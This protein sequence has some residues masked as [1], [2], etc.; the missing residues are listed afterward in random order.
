[1]SERAESPARH[2][3]RLT[4]SND[5]RRSATAMALAPSNPRKPLSANASHRRNGRPR[6]RCDAGPDSRA[7]DHGSPIERAMRRF[8]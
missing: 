8:R 1:M 2:V 5:D 3:L 6:R 7:A 4:A